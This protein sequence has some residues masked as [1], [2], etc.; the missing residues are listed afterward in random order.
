[1]WPAQVMWLVAILRIRQSTAKK[2]YL[3]LPH[4]IQ[5][6]TW[7]TLT[8]NIIQR[9]VKTCR[10]LVHTKEL[11]PKKKRDANRL[12]TTVYEKLVQKPPTVLCTNDSGWRLSA[13]P[14]NR[15]KQI[16]RAEWGSTFNTGQGG[17]ELWNQSIYLIKLQIKY[18]TF[19]NLGNF[20]SLKLTDFTN[21]CL[22]DNNSPL[23]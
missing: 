4:K 5:I 17:W 12:S 2:L 18:I 16:I 22:S 10:P 15:S 3:I 7:N 6:K 21:A 19:F 8:V 14:C 23:W 9:S 11:D 20:I 13:S 1:M